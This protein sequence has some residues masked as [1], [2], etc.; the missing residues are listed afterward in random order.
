MDDSHLDGTG[1]RLELSPDGGVLLALFTPVTGRRAVNAEELRR[2]IDAQGHGELFISGD[3]LH[4]LARRC[5]DAPSAFTL[6]IGYRSDA[7]LAVHLSEDRMAATMSIEPAHGGRRISAEDVQA[8]LA[9]HGVVSGI[10]QEEIEAALAAGSASKLIVAAGTPP[11]HGQNSQFIS[12]IPEMG[13]H[14]PQLSDDDTADYR[15]L[16]DIV[17]VSLGDPLVRRTPP[18]PGVAGR[19]LLGRELPAT[20]GCEIPFADNLTGVACELHDCELLIAAISGR[21]VIIPRGVIVEP[22]LKLKRVDLSTGNLHFKG[23]LE[24][25]GDVCE[26]M[27]VSATE[28]ITV[29]GVV[30][31]A[32]LRA[33]GDIEVKGGV[34]GHGKPGLDKADAPRK[35]A[36]LEAGG[37]VCVQFAENALIAAGRGIV[38]RELAMQ[39][40]LS[41]GTF[42]RVGAEG[43]RKGHIIGGLSRAATLVHAVVIGSYAGVPT[44]IEVGV[45][46]SLNRKL[47]TVKEA[48]AEKRRLT[49][50][51]TKTLAYLKENP[52]SMEPGLAKL[53]ERV[54][55]KYQAEIAELT[56]EKK[57]LQKRIE[58]NAQARV[59]VEREAF[60]G[61]RI[62]MGGC[63]LLIEEDLTGPTFTFTEEGICYSC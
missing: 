13:S 25:A 60:A 14:M 6:Q 21:P 36:Q 30:E 59:E 23:S 54:Y 56:G 28:Q 7:T 8:A 24:I 42:I 27:E 5:P 58:L 53:K 10:L 4:E 29:G 62:R 49:E 11:R 48:L 35:T 31:A 22:V 46:P 50:E 38:V 2:A 18:T 32:Q 43:T 17:S 20:D 40:E 61:A 26:G 12:L 33:G 39:C 37:T 16:G 51:L 41:S 3:A 44:V 47:D 15:N 55:D 1:I 19:D 63:S 9:G 34:I 57:R 45:D 52:A